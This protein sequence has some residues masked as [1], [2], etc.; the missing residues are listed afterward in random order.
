MRK[1]VILYFTPTLCLVL[2]WALLQDL[3]DSHHI[4]TRQTVVFPLLEM[5]HS[6]SEDTE[7]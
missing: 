3:L 6:V 7:T 1:L 4:T 5:D 2:C